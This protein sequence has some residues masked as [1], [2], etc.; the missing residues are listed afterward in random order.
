MMVCDRSLLY[1]LLVTF[2]THTNGNFYIFQRWSVQ[3]C[4]K[5]LSFPSTD[6]YKY[7]HDMVR[8]FETLP[9]EWSWMMSLL[10]S[11][12][13]MAKDYFFEDLR[14]ATYYNFMTL[15]VSETDNYKHFFKLLMHNLI[16][17]WSWI[18]EENQDN[19]W[20]TLNLIDFCPALNLL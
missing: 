18:H 7:V 6:Q 20:L 2:S 14:L 8:I 9:R 5:Y 16:F 3:L 12:N 13:S 17:S 11:K 1:L 10:K 15:K 4:S 19:Y